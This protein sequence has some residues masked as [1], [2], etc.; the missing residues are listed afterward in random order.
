[1]KKFIMLSAL[2]AATSTAFVA[3]SSDDDLAQQPKAPETTFDSSKGTPFSLSVS[4][5]TRATL[6]NADA[7]DGTDVGDGKWVSEIK[8]YGKQQNQTIPWMN[9]AVFTRNAY[10]S[11]D[12]AITRDASST[13]PTTPRWPKTGENP[14]Q[15]QPAIDSS[16]PTD[17]YAITDNAIGSETT[18]AIS[19][20]GAWMSKIN[21]DTNP[22]ASFT[23][24]MGTLKAD[25]PHIDAVSG[26]GYLQDPATDESEYVPYVDASKL[27][28]L[29]VAKATTT[30]PANGNLTLSNFTHVLA[31]LNIKLIFRNDGVISNAQ[32]N[33][34]AVIHYIKIMGLN[35]SGTYDFNAAGTDADPYWKGLSGAD[36][37]C[38]Y[39][40]FN[41]YQLVDSNED[42]YDEAPNTEDVTDFPDVATLTRGDVYTV[43]KKEIGTDVYYKKVVSPM[44]IPAVAESTTPSAADNDFWLVNKTDP[45]MVIP[46]KTT[47][48]VWDGKK[49][50]SSQYIAA[51][52]V[53]I[54]LGITDDQYTTDVE[55]FL[56][57]DTEFLAGANKTLRLDLGKFRDLYADAKPADGNAD[58]YFL[59]SDTNGSA[60]GYDFVD[61]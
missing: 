59:P 17:F 55:V 54:V 30:E 51:G 12:W 28:D 4:G 1:M 11:D 39:K 46:Q 43:Y 42:E 16:S 18:A 23:Y 8:L 3:C 7:W 47:D 27:K 10:D 44:T 33:H 35:T 5:E 6:Y 22:A 36:E 38:Y 15:G 48:N 50:A 53:Y 45:W 9:S 49:C 25:L 2:V 56:P 40:E 61:E 58:Y 24:T 20:V 31:G 34:Q 37:S 14:E 57:L 26:T 29:M 41:S 21:D 60:R 19:N 52:K 32:G 13:S